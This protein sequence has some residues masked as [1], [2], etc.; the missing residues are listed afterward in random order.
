MT[1]KPDAE[2]VRARRRATR[3]RTS[4]IWAA[5]AGLVVA[6][7][8]LW[9]V[10]DKLGLI[11]P[12]VLPTFTSIVHEVWRLVGESS[13]W[14]QLRVTSIETASAFLISSAAALL[15]G[16]L[17]S[18]QA[19]MAKLTNTLTSWAQLI[20]LVTIYPVF[21]ISMGIG[22][23]SKI[24]FAAVL[25]FFPVTLACVRALTSID[26]HVKSVAYFFGGSRLQTF[27]HVEIPAARF[28]LLAAARIGA[29]LSLIGIILGEMLGATEGIGAAIT[30]SGQTFDTQTLYAYIV[31][32]LI[33]T[34]IFNWLVNVGAREK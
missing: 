12:L 2:I 6:I 8:V 23:R 13:T 9:I 32:T 5:R 11:S 20:P 34:L 3:V 31:F 18:R 24:A 14:T 21:L 25:A 29:A 7:I 16:G 17:V 4:S 33:I 10:I 19:R 27:W 28:G 1:A 22:M 15:V 26:P 30:S